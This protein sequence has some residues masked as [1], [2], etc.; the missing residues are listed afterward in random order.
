MVVVHQTHTL[1]PFLPRNLF[2]GY[3]QWSLY[4]ERL[5]LLIFYAISLFFQ[6][7]KL[8]MVFNN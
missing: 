2:C 4:Q 3:K 7:L 1:L 6:I 5:I 8:I